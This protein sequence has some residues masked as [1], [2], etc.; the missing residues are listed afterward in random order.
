MNRILVVAALALSSTTLPAADRITPPQLLSSGLVRDQFIVELKSGALG[1]VLGRVPLLGQ[2]NA[3]L[4]DIPGAQ[5]VHVYDR[6]LIG[7]AVRLPLAQLPLL[8]A[9]PLVAKITQ[10]RVYKLI[11]TRA[12]TWGRDRIDQQSLPLSGT[13]SPPEPAG[14][15]A[16]VY[17]IDSGIHARHNEFSGRVGT[18]RNLVR[19]SSGGLDPNAW[20]DCNGHGTHVAG[21]AAGASY[22]VAPQATVHAVRVFSC[23]GAGAGADVLAGIEW[24]IESASAPAVVNM[25]LGTTGAR[26]AY[27]EQAVRNM[28]RAGIAVAVAAG[29]ENRDACLRSPAAEPSVLTVGAVT[30][31]DARASFSNYGS[32]VDLFAPGQGITAASHARSDAL[33]SFSGTSIATPHVAGALALIL[34]QQPR[35]TGAQ[36]Q[37]LLLGA[38]TRN[39]VTDAGS[40]S[41]NR[42]L[43]VAPAENA[44]RPAPSPSPPP[45]SSLP[46][47]DDAACADCTSVSDTLGENDALAIPSANGFESGGGAFKATLRSAAGTDFD[48]YLDHYARG[49]LLGLGGGW[50]AVAASESEGNREAIS[51][52]GGDGLYRWRVSAARGAGSF[53]LRYRNP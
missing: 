19:S 26:D 51:Y 27:L 40:S 43:F 35:L 50:R 30:Q 37:N 41:P 36:A 53:E 52:N 48:L 21:V 3:L 8:R 23:E 32:C 7:F 16:H 39:A 47:S 29:N 49:G 13:Y 20:T 42:L 9:N 5:L 11:D 1:G 45:P 34:S 46:P 14:R 33:A 6:A 22:G 28:V 10:D 44:A 17:I 18:G 25:S 2:V 12:R 24:V 38:T 4:T 15:G 31:N